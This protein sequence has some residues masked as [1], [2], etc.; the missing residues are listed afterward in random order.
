MRWSY[1]HYEQAR[2]DLRVEDRRHECHRQ[3]SHHVLLAA[4]FERAR[5][6]VD[7]HH[8]LL[9]RVALRVR[10]PLRDLFAEAPAELVKEAD[11]LAVCNVLDPLGEAGEEE[12]R[13]GLAEAAAVEQLE[14]GA[15]HKLRQLEE[16]EQRPRR[17]R[18][19]H[20]PLAHAAGGGAEG[21]EEGVDDGAALEEGGH[22]LLQLHVLLLWDP[23]RHGKHV[24]ELLQDLLQA[25]VQ[26]GQDGAVGRLAHQKVDGRQHGPQ[27]DLE[28]VAVLFPH[29]HRELV[30]AVA[31]QHA[32]QNRPRRRRS[33]R[34][35]R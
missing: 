15:E 24:D 28:H 4:L 34:R 32:A 13:V 22:L 9:A 23:C 29:L 21:G 16:D 10:L 12:G 30:P 8:R 6:Q 31:L 2:V 19:A 33:R 7:V 3:Q 25:G 27:V 1:G 18:P 14:V 20:P 17:R 35:R 26:V 11:E 5:L